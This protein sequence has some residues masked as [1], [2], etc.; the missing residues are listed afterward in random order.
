[1]KNVAGYSHSRISQYFNKRGDQLKALLLVLNIYC[2]STTITTL[3]AYTYIM[4]HRVG[5]YLTRHDVSS[6]CYC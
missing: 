3:S 4:T 2:I 6:T 5:N 1:M